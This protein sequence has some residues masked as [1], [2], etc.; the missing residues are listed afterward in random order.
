MPRLPLPPL[1]F[2]STSLDCLAETK[3][4]FKVTT[5]DA[6]MYFVGVELFS[7]HD[8]YFPVRSKFTKTRAGRNMMD[9]QLS[10]AMPQIPV[11]N[12]YRRLRLHIIATAAANKVEQKIIGMPTAKAI[13]RVG[14]SPPSAAPPIVQNNPNNSTQTIEIQLTTLNAFEPIRWSIMGS[15]ESVE[16]IES[17]R[18]LFSA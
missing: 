9:L 6:C 11:R 8:P 13:S 2:R 3:H 15:I 7:C 5:L 18:S 12:G 17:S 14:P 1:G 16:S 4:N 10:T